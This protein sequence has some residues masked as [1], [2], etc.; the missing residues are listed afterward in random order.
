M[1]L[2]LTDR[3]PALDKQQLINLRTNARRLEAAAGDRA[4]DAAALLPLI[5][6]ELSRRTP[7][8]PAKPR[9]KRAK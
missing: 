6:A 1:A 8:E 9:A 2:D 3:L 5:E 7:S 4:A